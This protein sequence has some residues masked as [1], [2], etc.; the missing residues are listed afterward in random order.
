MTENEL[1]I[2]RGIIERSK[3]NSKNIH[4]CMAYKNLLDDLESTVT[5]FENEA[6]TDKLC[7]PKCLSTNVHFDANPGYYFCDHC[8]NIWKRMA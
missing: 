2:F 7:C 3:S 5:T 6:S 1:L 4:T 8:L